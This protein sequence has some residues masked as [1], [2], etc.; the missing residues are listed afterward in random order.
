M[1]TYSRDLL[2]PYKHS[3]AIPRL[4]ISYLYEPS[5]SEQLYKANLERQPADWYYRHNSVTYTWNSNGYRAPEWT[6]VDWPNTW[7]VMGCSHVVGIGVAEQHT[8]SSHLSVLLGKPC[9]NLGMGGSGVDVIMYNSLRLIDNAIK[10]AGVVVVAPQLARMTY[11]TSKHYECL[12]AGFTRHEVDPYIKQAY[13]G[14]LRYEPNA[15]MQGYMKLRGVQALWR[16]EGV[17]IVMSHYNEGKAVK[18]IGLALPDRQDAARD[19]DVID[20]LPTGH[21][22]FKTLYSW[23]SAIANTI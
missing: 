10:P 18:P 9:I 16:S 15:E 2:L 20:G 13:E 4:G 23:A 11:W 3:L 8:L 19:V 14:F 7:I 21:N 1:Q 17:P 22:G 6:E 5:D 12:V